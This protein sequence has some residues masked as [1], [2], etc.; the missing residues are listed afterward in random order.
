MIGISKT[1]LTCCFDPVV[2]E[3]DLYLVALTTAYDAFPQ[4]DIGNR[5]Q[6]GA[7]L[8]P[9][10]GELFQE[11]ER[12]AIDV[13]QRDHDNFCCAGHLNLLVVLTEAQRL[14]PT[15]LTCQAPLR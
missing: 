12:V 13:P 7:N 14:T 8:A 15:L 3:G 6:Q 2:A 1:E 4:A 11:P 9:A 5:C 10:E